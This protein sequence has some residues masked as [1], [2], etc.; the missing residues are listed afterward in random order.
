[1]AA[2]ESTQEIE[3]LAGEFVLG[4]VPGQ[5]RADAMFRLR[6]DPEFKRA[7]DAWEGRLGPLATLVEPIDPPAGLENRLMRLIAGRQDTAGGEVF[8]L[9]RR[10]RLWQSASLAAAAAVGL[11]L[12]ALFS[13][14]PRNAGLSPTAERYVA[15][16]QPEGQGPAFVA[17]VDLNRG[18]VSAQSIGAV[19][20]AGKSFELWAVGAGRE[21]PQSLGV[22][23]GSLRIPLDK[24]GKTSRQDL[25]NTILAVS[26]EPKGGSPTGAATGPIV[27]TGKLIP[28]E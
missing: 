11:L 1:M 14:L 6:T 20:E 21:K 15:V 24:L 22:I 19:P 28:A 18:I 25:Q 7:V 13:L 3:E 4:V 9:Q 10:L 23:D 5:E 27:Y 17:T 2:P 12:I 16:L 8:Q 26:T